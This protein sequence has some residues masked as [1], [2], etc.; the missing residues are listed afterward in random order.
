M[1]MTKIQTNKTKTVYFMG[2]CLANLYYPEVGINAID[3]LKR[4]GIEVI[5]PK[6][7][8]CCA[9][10]SFNSGYRDEARKVAKTLIDCFTKDIPVIVPAGSCAA[11]I[12]NQYDELF[13]S[14]YYLPK[15]QKLKTNICE[16]TEFLVDVL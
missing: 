13:E 6:N 16:L 12:K 9:Q 11:M 3:I 8:T 5:Y 14:D 10:P 4:E 1:Y 7:Q 15:V 2:T